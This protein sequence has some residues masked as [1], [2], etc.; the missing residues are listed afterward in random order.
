M[1]YGREL[2]LFLVLVALMVAAAMLEPR[3]VTLRT[4]TLLAA[5]SWELALVAIPMLLIIIAGGIDLSVGA[6]VALSAVTLGL[7]HERGAP[8]MLA[9]SGGLAVG[10][11][12]GLING[13][14]IARTRVHPLLITLASMAAFRGIAEGIS[15][16]RPISGYPE[17]L[18]SL[19]AGWKP[20]VIFVVMAVTA[21]VVL[22]RL[23]WGRWI[24]AI[25]TDEKVSRFSKIPVDRVKLMLYSACGLLCGLAGVLLVARNNTAKA[26]LGMGMELEAITAV[27]L[28]G[29]SI[30]G[31]KG[32]VLG[33]VLG[34]VL[35]HETRQ[36]V[37]WH[38]R[39]S[40]LNLLVIGG[41]LIVAV[42]FDRLGR[43]VT[44]PS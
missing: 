7:L 12:C 35:I 8:P 1:K 11:V 6:I 14:L 22:T 4:Q 10:L 26:D 9:A 43:R 24:V 28:G 20:A 25:G 30:E 17:A 31:G 37:S 13:W 41:L 23:R 38:W 27:V 40:E 3:F 19:S 39:Q 16:A 36:F 42:L 2:T 32:R 44:M 15:T 5:H 34:L 18:L 29:A 21:H 33:L